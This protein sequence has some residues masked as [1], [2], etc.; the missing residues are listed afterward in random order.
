MI[1]IISFI[2]SVE[3]NNVNLF[4]AFAAP[5]P[6]IFLSNLFIA[7]EAKLLSNLG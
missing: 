4:P 6:L 7:F 3:I 5:F 1:F 2:F